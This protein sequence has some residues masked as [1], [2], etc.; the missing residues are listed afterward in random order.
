MHT[1]YTGG[2][3][4]KYT[5]RQFFTPVTYYIAILVADILLSKQHFLLAL[6]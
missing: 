4:E 3:K 2:T 5:Q 1:S 6:K